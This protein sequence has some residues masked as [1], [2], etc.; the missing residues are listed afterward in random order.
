MATIAY[1]YA[2]VTGASWKYID[3]DHFIINAT[4]ACRSSVSGVQLLSR[5]ASVVT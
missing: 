1:S 4:L 3:Y 5:T 2:T